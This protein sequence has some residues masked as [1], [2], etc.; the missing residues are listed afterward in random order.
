MDHIQDFLDHAYE[1]DP[2]EKVTV[3]AIND[4]YKNW[5]NVAGVEPVSRESFPD[6]MRAKG[7]E[8]GKSGDVR[9]WMGLRL[10][11]ATAPAS[12]AQTITQTTN[13]K[14]DQEDSASAA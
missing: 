3:K 8:Q 2:R 9:Y 11:I 7:F 4:A 6:L 1:P 13:P 14:S 5:V 12:Q 10:K